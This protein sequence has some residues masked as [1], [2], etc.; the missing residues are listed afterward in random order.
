MVFIISAGGS[1]STRYL[2][3]CVK[4]WDAFGLGA[5]LKVCESLCLESIFISAVNGE[6]RK[7]TGELYLFMRMEV[8]RVTCSTLHGTI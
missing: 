3:L 2:A 5:V 7:I 1:V 4:W 6:K 8:S